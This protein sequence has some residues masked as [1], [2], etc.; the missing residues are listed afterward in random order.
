MWRDNVI[1]DYTVK[2]EIVTKGG[3]II[4]SITITQPALE[5]VRR[6]LSV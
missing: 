1:T 3:K 5:S 4:G 6:Y 2:G